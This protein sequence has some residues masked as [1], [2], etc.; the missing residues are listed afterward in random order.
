MLVKAPRTWSSWPTQQHSNFILLS[1]TLAAA[2]LSPMST[3]LASWL[4]KVLGLTEEWETGLPPSGSK[5]MTMITMVMAMM[6]QL[7]GRNQGSACGV[8]AGVWGRGGPRH[9]RTV[10]RVT[11]FFYRNLFY[12]FWAKP[13]GFQG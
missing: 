2:V 1:H 10:G 4:S 8:G 9:P 5:A 7:Q 11:N 12:C 6:I 3:W 13:G